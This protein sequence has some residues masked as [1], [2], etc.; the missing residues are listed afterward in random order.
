MSKADWTVFL[1]TLLIVVIAA[2][3]SFFV[4]AGVV[5]FHNAKQHPDPNAQ[6]QSHL[7]RIGGA[8]CGADE[9]AVPYLATACAEAKS[10]C[11]SGCSV[12]DEATDLSGIPGFSDPPLPIPPDVDQPAE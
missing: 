4:S 11:G 10:A 7:Q 1:N 6:T 12:W 2:A 5:A 3:V 9:L 8:V